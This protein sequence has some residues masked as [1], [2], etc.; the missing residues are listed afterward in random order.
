MDVLLLLLCPQR[1]YNTDL[2]QH[3]KYI[4]TFGP[5]Y[6]LFG[7]MRKNAH[8]QKQ[9]N[10]GFRGNVPPSTGFQT[11]KIQRIAFLGCYW[12]KC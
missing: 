11:L 8:N 1:K 3:N 10:K 5:K 6:V 9:E 12:R 7:E 4:I 2:R